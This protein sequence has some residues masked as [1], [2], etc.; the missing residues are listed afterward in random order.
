VKEGVLALVLVCPTCD[1][2]IF[3]PAENC[4]HDGSGD[5]PAAQCRADCRCSVCQNGVLEPGEHCEYDLDAA[6]PGMC[7][8]TC[9]CTGSAAA[10]GNGF[11]DAGETCDGANGYCGLVDPLLPLVT[12]CAPPGDASGC[13]CCIPEA[14]I[15]SFYGFGEPCCS[16]NV[17]VEQFVEGFI[18]GICV[19]PG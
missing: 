3:S 8:S 17:C 5:C 1:D 14:G 18:V 11:I 6:C 10:C 4:E 13:R 12:E 9:G 7:N 19:P 2:G 15:C 16:G